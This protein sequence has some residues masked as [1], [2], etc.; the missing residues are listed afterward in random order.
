MRILKH[1]VVALLAFSLLACGDKPASLDKVQSTLNGFTL[2]D[3]QAGSISI[4]P[5]QNNFLRLTLPLK[6]FRTG[7]TIKSEARN[8]WKELGV[9]AN[10]NGKHYVSSSKHA[11][12]IDVAIKTVSPS[13]RKM[14]FRVSAKLVE[15]ASGK[16]MEFKTDVLEINGK[17]YDDLMKS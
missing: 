4:G 10:W 3:N 17:Q 1:L 15:P 9:S 6:N 12:Y 14:T 7:Y 16:Y 11:T 8:H 2:Y 5:D 13:E